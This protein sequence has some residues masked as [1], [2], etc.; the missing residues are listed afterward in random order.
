MSSSDD[1]VAVTTS[2][3]TQEKNSKK[4]VTKAEKSAPIDFQIKPAKG[5]PS[6]DTSSWPLLLKVMMP[7]IISKYSCKFSWLLCSK[8]VSWPLLLNWRGRTSFNGDT[9]QSEIYF[10]WSFD[11][12]PNLDNRTLT[13]WTWRPTISLRFHA[14][15]PQL[16]ALLL[17]S[18][19]TVSSTLTSPPTPLLTKS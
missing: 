8:V 14:D 10:G 19:A 17:S 11:L 13:S 16:A 7:D 12:W 3:K 18:S 9:K 4:T 15:G 5:G 1:E 6:M 2:K